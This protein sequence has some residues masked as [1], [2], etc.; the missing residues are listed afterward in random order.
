VHLHP[1]CSPLHDQL[2]VRQAFLAAPLDVPAGRG[3]GA[4]PG[5]Q[6]PPQGVAG[7]A[8]PA[9]IEPVTG[10]LPRR[11]RDRCSGAQ[12]RPGRLRAQPCRMTARRLI[13]APATARNRISVERHNGGYFACS[14]VRRHRSTRE[15]GPDLGD[16]RCRD[17]SVKAW[18]GPTKKPDRPDPAKGN[19]RPGRS[20]KLLTPGYRHVGPPSAAPA[21]GPARC[22]AGPA[23]NRVADGPRYR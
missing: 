16:P 4:H 10:A 18:F 19:R 3:T 2:V 12:V 8:V 6:D 9:G 23:H 20:A 21:G 17:Q 15:P 11:C 22:R 1:A 7:L 13:R 14:D 5:D